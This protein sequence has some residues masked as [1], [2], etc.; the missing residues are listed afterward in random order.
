[1]SCIAVQLAVP[2][3]FHKASKS[4]HQMQPTP[5]RA[6][7]ALAEQSPVVDHDMCHWRLVGQAR[8]CAYLVHPFGRCRVGSIASGRQA[9]SSCRG[10]AWSFP[11]SC[12]VQPQSAPVHLRNSGWALSVSTC[13]A[14]E[15]S[16]QAFTLLHCPWSTM[17]QYGVL[18]EECKRPMLCAPRSLPQPLW[19]AI[20]CNPSTGQQN[21][22]PDAH[23][24]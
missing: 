5:Q 8:G 18:P 2:A 24:E 22:N 1:M 13:Q 6:K 9:C 11:C 14:C 3:T 12:T 21:I 19:T 23:H 16:A 20:N 17:G 15:L 4:L 10:S 7:P